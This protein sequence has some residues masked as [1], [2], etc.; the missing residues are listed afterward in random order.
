M[1][2]RL[3][4]VLG[5]TEPGASLDDRRAAVDRVRRRLEAF[6]RLHLD[7]GHLREHGLAHVLVHG[8]LGGQPL[9]RAYRATN[10]QLPALDRRALDGWCAAVTG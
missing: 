6:A 4:H 3:A 2:E 1:T 8:Q 5:E 10:P 9:A 7:A